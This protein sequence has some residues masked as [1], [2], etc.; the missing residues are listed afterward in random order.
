MSHLGLRAGLRLERFHFAREKQ[1]IT[2]HF[3]NEYMPI[4]LRFAL[5][6]WSQV[7]WCADVSHVLLHKSSINLLGLSL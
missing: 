5:H 7:L 1:E 2:P 4:A 6:S 3:L